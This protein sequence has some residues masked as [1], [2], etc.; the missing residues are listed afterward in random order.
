M[1]C[2]VERGLDLR[3]TVDLCFQPMSLRA[4]SGPEQGAWGLAQFPGS[5][6]PCSQKHWHPFWGGRREAG[7]VGGRQPQARESDHV[8]DPTQPASLQGRP[9]EPW[10][11]LTKMHRPHTAAAVASKEGLVEEALE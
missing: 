11:A 2:S 5:R 1:P 4:H 8:T 9:A 7:G 3:P 6:A 10:R